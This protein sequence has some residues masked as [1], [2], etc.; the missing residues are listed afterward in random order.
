VTSV[1]AL[2]TT[3]KT[4]SVKFKGKSIAELLDTTVEEAVAAARK[5]SSDSAKTTNAAG[6]WSRLSEAW[7][8]SDHSV[9]WGSQRIKLAKE[10]SKRATGRTVY[11]L[12]EPTPVFILRTFI[13]CSTFSSVSYLWAT[14]LSSS[15][16]ISMLFKSAD[17]IVDLGPEGGEHGGRV[18][19]AGTPEE[20]ARVRRSY[21]GQYFAPCSMDVSQKTATG[22]LEAKARRSRDNAWYTALPW[23]SPKNTWK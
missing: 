11:M 17:Y 2:A 13:S 3:A 21:T 10:L 12:D 19:A 15:N 4:L 20:V 5:R 7:T 1:A 18:V 9:G 8:I 6:R 16:T 23:K 22:I 14:R